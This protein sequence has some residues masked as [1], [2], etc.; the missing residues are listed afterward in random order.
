MKIYVLGSKGMLGKYVNTYLSQYFH[1]VNITRNDINASNINEEELHAKLLHIGLKSDD[2][3]VNCIGAIKP[4][5]DSLGDLN[6]LKVNSIFPRI[7]S[8]VCEKI[9]AKM[10][11]PTTDCVFTGNRG[12]YNENDVHDISDVYG[13]SKSLGEPNNCMVIRTSIIG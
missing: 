1:V 2:I 5:V 3:V 11:H 13:R 9:G 6:A 12:M 7:L 8:N 10:I 4:I